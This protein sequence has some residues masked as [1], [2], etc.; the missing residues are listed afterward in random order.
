MNDTT[1]IQ[2]S[3]TSLSAHTIVTDIRSITGATRILDGLI[4]FIDTTDGRITR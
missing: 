2:N 3:Q 4:A 1:T